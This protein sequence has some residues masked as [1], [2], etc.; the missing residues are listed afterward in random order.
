MF[1]LM[2]W[3]FFDGDREGMLYAGALIQK[4]ET[5]HFWANAGGL[6]MEM[7]F[8]HSHYWKLSGTPKKFWIH[9]FQ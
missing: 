1:H 4:S 2:K 3:S 5:N 9:Y 8:M 6:K 7:A